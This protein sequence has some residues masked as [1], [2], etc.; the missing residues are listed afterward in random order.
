MMLLNGSYLSGKDSL[1]SNLQISEEKTQKINE[2]VVHE[3]L[4]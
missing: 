2:T 4:K 1:M 3:M